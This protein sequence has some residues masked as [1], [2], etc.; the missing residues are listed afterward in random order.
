FLRLVKKVGRPPAHHLH[1]V[2]DEMPDRL[3][4]AQL[5]RL[6]VYDRQ[7]DHAEAFLH[8]S[9]LV[10]LVEHDLRLSSTLQFNHDAHA[11]AITLVANVGD[12]LDGLVV[13]E[14]GDALDEPGFVYLVGNFGDDNGLAVFAEGFNGGARAHHEASAA[15]AVG[16]EYS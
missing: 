1:P 16:F 15:G 12:V 3:D 14:V 7:Q 10:E 11:I 4:E 13:D 8:G 2:I 6:A 9:V 5:F